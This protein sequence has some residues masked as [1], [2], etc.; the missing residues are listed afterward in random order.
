MKSKVEAR[1]SV[2]NQCDYC[3]ANG[4]CG[5]A[6]FDN[7][8][9][10]CEGRSCVA[11]QCDAETGEAA[12][13]FCG[14]L[15]CNGT[16][17]NGKCDNFNKK[18]RGENCPELIP[19]KSTA[20]A[21][22]RGGDIPVATRYRD[23]VSEQYVAIETAKDNL[24]RECVKFGALLLEV[25]YY[26]GEA[27]GRGNKGGGL[28]GW[29]AENCPQINYDTAMGYKKMGEMA[30]AKIGGGSQAVAVL[31]DK[32]EV[33]PPGEE[34][35]IEVESKFIEKRDELFNEVKSRRELEQTYFKF[36]ASE[37]KG[38]PG[39]K[40]G[41]RDQ[42]SG[43]GDHGRVKTRTLLEMALLYAEP[44]CTA[45][46]KPV[47]HST[48]KDLQGWDRGLLEEYVANVEQYL[49]E[50]KEVLKAR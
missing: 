7:Y 40:A 46:K 6:M 34:E 16:C 29:L 18:C 44:I 23:R 33:V 50:L 26:L 3:R 24:L 32:T 42:G 4:K 21:V 49:K 12:K 38:K 37:G 19:V 22:A 2:E 36:M 13:W 17:G 8:G 15:R 9:T 47:T 20:V 5:R 43:I 14:E 35:A 1:K 39:R 27:R 11:W 48:V 41:N 28:K 10:T 45:L 30:V 31:Q 25:G